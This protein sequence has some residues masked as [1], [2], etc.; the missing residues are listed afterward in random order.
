MDEIDAVAELANV[1][2]AYEMNENNYTQESKHSRLKRI[3]N[4]L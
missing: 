2:V 3:R 1:N 4:Q